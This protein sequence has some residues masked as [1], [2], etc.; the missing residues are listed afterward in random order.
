MSKTNN[1]MNKLNQRILALG[2]IAMAGGIAS[3]AKA[4]ISYTISDASLEYADVQYQ[5]SEYTVLAGGIGITANNVS[6][7]LPSG[8]NPSS[9]PSTY[10]SVCTD[11]AASLYL[12]DTYSYNAPIPTANA[13]TTPGYSPDPA[14]GP[15][16][17]AAI[18]NAATLF[19]NFGS[20]LSGSDLDKAAG[21]QL[22]VWMALY[23]STGVGTLNLGSNAELLAA[24]NGSGAT[25]DA[26]SFL[27]QLAGLTPNTGVDIFTPDPDS[28]T[29][30]N[31]PDGNPPQ[32][33]LLYAP[34]P[35]ASTVITA[36]LLLLS[37]GMC[38]LKSFGKF[39]A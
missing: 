7:S 25:A 19:A 10:V 4:D 33:L 8:P 23:D 28:P 11:F 3:Q 9:G 5:G 27:S 15:N 31:N 1:S 20:V 38:S 12:G 32:G 16:G 14:W 30:G 2:A 26:Y 39:R 36:S 18:Q 21:L 6:P 35:E 17:S 29:N 24:S 34:V 37:F 22:A 13:L